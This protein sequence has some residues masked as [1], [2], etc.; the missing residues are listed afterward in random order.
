MIKVVH[1][2]EMARLESLSYKDYPEENLDII[3]SQNFKLLNKSQNLKNW[4]IYF[5]NEE[6][7]GQKK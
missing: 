6:T 7:Y 4:P 5:G 2:K 3:A 1:G